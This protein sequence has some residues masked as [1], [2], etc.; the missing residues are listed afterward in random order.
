MLKADNNLLNNLVLD[1]GE[2]KLLELFNYY[3]DKDE[4][5][6]LMQSLNSQS[7]KEIHQHFQAEMDEEYQRRLYTNMQ[8]E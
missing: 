7:I 3:N 5:G 1:D 8:L 2:I 4:L 6:K